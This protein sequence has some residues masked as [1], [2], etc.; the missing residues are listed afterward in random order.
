MFLVEAY[1][2][3]PVL[4][5]D[6]NDLIPNQLQDPVHHRFEALQDFLIRERHVAL[7]NTSLREFSLDTNVYSP[8]LAVVSEIGLYP[9]L[10]IHDALRVNFASRLRTVWQLHL[11][12]LC[13]KDVTEIT[14]ERS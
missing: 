7:F 8:L 11:P 10:E 14:V 13:T 5:L 9:V 2:Q 6:S 3:C 1:L 4:C 12:N